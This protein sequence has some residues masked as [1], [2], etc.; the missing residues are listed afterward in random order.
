MHRVTAYVFHRF[1]DPRA[2]L[3]RRDYRLDQRTAYE[4]D[5]RIADFLNTGKL[6]ITELIFV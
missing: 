4:L 6:G 3:A 5:R 1:Y 2:R